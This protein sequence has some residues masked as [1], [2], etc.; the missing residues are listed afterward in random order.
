MYGIGGANLTRP[1][2]KAISS[3]LALFS[4]ALLNLKSPICE[5]RRSE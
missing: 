2:R 3:Q 1:L 4:F 5:G